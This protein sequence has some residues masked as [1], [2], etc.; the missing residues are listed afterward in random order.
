MNNQ[1]WS[2]VDKLSFGD[3]ITL[4]Y[5]QLALILCGEAFLYIYALKGALKVAIA[6]AISCIYIQCPWLSYMDY[7]TWIIC[8]FIICIRKDSLDFPSSTWCLDFKWGRCFFRSWWNR[9]R[10]LKVVGQFIITIPS[11]PALRKHETFTLKCRTWYVISTTDLPSYQCLLRVIF[12]KRYVCCLTVT[13]I[14]GCPCCKC[15]LSLWINKHFLII[16]HFILQVT[17]MITDW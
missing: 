1:P 11:G 7:C 6:L 16:Q 4:Y 3:F 17:H 8:S 13:C 2:Y 10:I 12:P 9:N 14:Y 15:I 5:E